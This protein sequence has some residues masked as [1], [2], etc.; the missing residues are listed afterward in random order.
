LQSAEKAVQAGATS[1]L[2]QEAR[3]DALLALGRKDEAVAAYQKALE[4]D[5]KLSRARIGLASALSAGGKHAEAV[6]EAKK[7]TTAEEKNAEAYAALGLALLAQNPGNFGGAIA[8]AQQGAFLNPKSVSAQLAVAKIFEASGNLDQAAAA[9]ERASQQDPGLFALRV[10][11]LNLKFPVGRVQQK[12]REAKDKT[13]NGGLDLSK[14]VL[15]RDEGY[16]QLLRLAAEQPRSGDLQYQV[17]LYQLYVEDY[18]GAADALKKAT[19]LS[20]GLA[21]AWAYYG[22]AAQYLGRTAEAVGAYKKAVELDPSNIT[23]RT[24]YG[25]LLGVNGQPA[26][27]VAEL[28]KVTTSP[29]YKDS[30]GF[31]NLG[32]LYRNMTPKK[33]QESVDAYKKALALDPKNAQAA[34]G[35]GWAYSYQQSYDEGIAAFQKA[36]QIDPGVTGEAYD[37]IAWCYFFKQ[38]MAQATAALDKAQAAGRSDPKLRQVIAKVAELKEKQE[39]YK[40]YLEEQEKLRNAGPD[41]GTLCRQV[42]TGDTASKIRAVRALGEKGR[43]AIS[44]LIRAL[45]EVPDVRGAAA[46]ELAGL[47]PG[48]KQAVPYLMEVLKAECGKTIMTKQELDESV[49]CEDAKRKARDAVNRIGR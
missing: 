12:Y 4:L 48:A 40:K 38:D 35:M 44:C 23:F 37:G 21:P 2:A 29:G 8:E 13:P 11:L 47:G 3:G 32:W 33:T 46:D 19:E 7:V 20:P 6:A 41:L 26:E 15:A 17:G 39:L 9:Y 43:E 25:L 10:R 22:T 5:G 34:L 31:T 49:K 18:K 16:Q 27:G 28:L 45:D 24:T 14:A 36:L 30:A 1:A 42:S